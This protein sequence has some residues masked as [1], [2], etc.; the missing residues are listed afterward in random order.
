MIA[1]LLWIYWTSPQPDVEAHI[2]RTSL[3]TITGPL[4]VAAVALAH[5]LGRLPRATGAEPPVGPAR[6]A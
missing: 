5:V 4:F 6:R 2:E 1:G 3:R